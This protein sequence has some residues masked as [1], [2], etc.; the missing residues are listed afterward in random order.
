MTT[1]G[2]NTPQTE[3]VEGRED[4]VENNEGGF[5][6]S[7]GPWGM[8]DRFLILGSEGNTYYS[9]ERK[10][11]KDNVKNVEKLLHTDGVDV[12]RRVVE[13]SESGRAPKNDQALYILAMA[14]SSENP[15]VRKAALDA[16]LK[17]A[18]IGTHLFH[19]VSFV[20]EMRGWGRSLRKAVS[21]WYLETENNKLAYQ[22]IKYQQRDG[23]SHS[24]VIRLA[25]P[26]PADPVKDALFAWIRDPK[27]LGNKEVNLPA[28]VQAFEAAKKAS[29]S[30][31]IIR[32]IG[33]FNLPRECIPTNFL[34]DP[35]VWEALLEKMPMTAVI[36]NLATMTSVGL[37]TSGSSAATKVSNQITDINLLRRARIHPISVLSALRTYENGKGIRGSK[38]WSPIKQVCDAL[39]SSFY[40]SFG[41]VIP[42]GKRILVALDVSG[43]MAAGEI[44]GVPG[45]TPRDASAALALVTLSVEPNVEV[46]GFTNGSYGSYNSSGITPLNLQK[47]YEN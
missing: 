29:S 47:R 42:T 43:S 38:T 26:K 23:W 41:N 24:D 39:D 9:S 31:E 10:I 12:V 40:L 6:F 17:V 7:V 19:Y 16:L 28:Q 46:V 33:D 20:N 36:R 44:A 35:T 2:L 30:A 45:L 34:T 15:K 25:H 4:Q 37:L 1:L 8:L 18:R 3:K 13:I 11:T 27:S 21:N 5:V 14:S 22:L 32:L